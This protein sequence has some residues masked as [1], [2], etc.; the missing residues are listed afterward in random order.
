[1]TKPRAKIAVA[2]AVAA[3]LAATVA[4]VG[5]AR[6]RFQGDKEDGKQNGSKRGGVEEFKTSIGLLRGVE[7]YGREFHATLRSDAIECLENRRVELKRRRFLFADPTI[8]QERGGPNVA[9]PR[10]LIDPGGDETYYFQADPVVVEDD[11]GDRIKCEKGESERFKAV[12]RP[13]PSKG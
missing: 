4:P 2:I 1:M 11:D 10:N 3:T 5:D 9:F 6:I 8:A 7:N 12:T 13:D